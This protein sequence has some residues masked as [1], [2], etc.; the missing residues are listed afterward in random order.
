MVNEIKSIVRYDKR[1][2]LYFFIQF[3]AY[4]FLPI[5]TAYAVASLINM[6][7][8]RDF[9]IKIGFILLGIV[10]IKY[11]DALSRNRIEAFSSN[12]RVDKLYTI[13]KQYLSVDYS[14]LENPDFI[15]KMSAAYQ[16]VY[17]SDKAFG[18]ITK[19]LITLFSQASSVLL[20]LYYFFMLDTLFLALIIS[21]LIL[22]AVLSK[23]KRRNWDK[24]YEKESD[25][26]K[27][28]RYISDTMN[29]PSNGKDIRLFGMEDVF[30]TK[31][32]SNIKELRKIRADKRKFLH[33]ETVIE[34]IF[35]VALY[36]LFLS[37]LLHNPNV[38]A[39][40]AIV[41]FSILNLVNL[42]SSK[43]ITTTYEVRKDLSDIQN[44]YD[45]IE[46][47]NVDELTGDTTICTDEIKISFDHVSYSYDG[48][49]NVLNNVSFDINTGDNV[50]VVGDNGAGKSTII[51]LM[52]GLYKPTSGKIL[53]N[54]RDISDFNLKAYHKLFSVIFQEQHQFYES[55][56]ESIIEGE[57]WNQEKFDEV[58]DK[59]KLKGL[60][61][62]LPSGIDTNLVS[63]IDSDGVRLSGGELQR[64]K[65][66]RAIYKDAPIFIL[67]EPT[68]ALDPFVEQEL[69]NM[70]G[71]IMNGKT[72]LYISHRLSSTKFCNKIIVLRHGEIV[73]EGTHDELIEKEGYYQKVY[74]I[75]KEAY[76]A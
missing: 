27:R 2:V 33:I 60:V 15:R 5:L 36:V 16:C 43:I 12:Y 72:S 17:G 1:V 38:D 18:S 64:L 75:Q 69:F 7:S 28:L 58:I 24:N 22:L 13:N 46:I 29:V 65:F 25:V 3:I 50:A 70:Y 21:K 31:F 76:H 14:L 42:S 71:D 4:I 35:S 10:V 47:Q 52:T 67:D 11:A 9:L 37:V 59:S 19:D 41:L 39:T 40:S 74:T 20:I 44:Y 30:R 53:F 57:Q 49:K 48:E 26:Q 6:E 63:G 34:L 32:N 23:Y 66:A 73:D 54:G 62:K 68:S 51:K 61:D 56:K 45:Y 8:I 55:F